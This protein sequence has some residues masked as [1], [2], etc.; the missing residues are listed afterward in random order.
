MRK[1]WLLVIPVIGLAGL[2]VVMNTVSAGRKLTI[3]TCGIGWSC[4]IDTPNLDRESERNLST[5][6]TEFNSQHPNA[7]AQAGDVITLCNDTVCADYTLTEDGKFVG[8]NVKA[9]TRNGA[10]GGG[11]AGGGS[12]GGGSGGG[13]AGVGGG[14]CE[15]ECGGKVIVGPVKP[16]SKGGG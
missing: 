9:Q 1:K 14:G 16:P 3:H 11:S 7:P 10:G 2:V 5:L 6:V 8:S 13:W 12:T 15:S 4:A